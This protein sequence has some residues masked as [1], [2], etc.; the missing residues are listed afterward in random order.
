[1]TYSS[2]GTIAATDYNTRA[3]DVNNIWGT[4]S[5][6]NGYGQS[7]T[8]SA[9]S[10]AGTVTASNWASMISRLDSIR[11][12]QSATTSGITQPAAGNTITFLSGLDTQISTVIT[13][14]LVP[15]TRGTFYYTG[16]T[17]LTNTGT[18]YTQ[19]LQQVHYSWGSYDQM[20]YFFN[21][22]GKLNFII[23]SVIMLD[24]IY[25]PNSKQHCKIPA[26]IVI[27]AVN[28]I[29]LFSINKNL[30]NAIVKGE[31]IVSFWLI[32]V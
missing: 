11:A 12:H 13:N 7:T 18:W 22:G 2:G 25:I 8:L 23:S 24:C 6:A 17:Q 9:V 4:G 20:R 32:E 5:G 3:T 26:N 27:G 19:G 15:A 29:F 31:D 28:S 21:A 30:F 10:A 1:M 16:N 14:K